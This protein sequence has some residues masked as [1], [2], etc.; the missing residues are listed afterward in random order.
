[1]QHHLPH[2]HTQHPPPVARVLLSPGGVRKAG[3]VWSG[4]GYDQ[5]AVDAEEVVGHTIIR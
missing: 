3:F 1:M 5:R 4:S 2:G